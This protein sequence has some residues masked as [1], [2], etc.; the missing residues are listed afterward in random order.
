MQYFKPYILTKKQKDTLNQQIDD[1]EV[2][3]EK[4][5]RKYEETH[6]DQPPLPWKPLPPPLAKDDSIDVEHKDGSQEESP[7]VSKPS[8]GS[9]TVVKEEPVSKMDGAQERSPEQ[10]KDKSKADDFDEDVIETSE[11]GVSLIY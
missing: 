9:E 1:T 2:R 6:P 3:I 4:I 10:K 5:V 8:P 11:G 7:Q